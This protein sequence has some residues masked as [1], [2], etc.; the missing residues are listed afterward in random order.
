[1]RIF[2]SYAKEQ[3]DI[4]ESIALA[5]RSK[6]HTV[7]F[8]R[9]DL[10]AGLGYDDL[11]RKAINRSQL[12]IFII[13]PESIAAGRYT[14]TE[15][16]FARRRWPSPHGRVLPVRIRPTPME[17]IP[18]YLKAV[19]I[20]EPSGNTAT[21]VA[22]AVSAL[23]RGRNIRYRAASLGMGMAIIGMSFVL[24]KFYV[25][26]QNPP[27]EG[28]RPPV[29]GEKQEPSPVPD[30]NLDQSNWI[31]GGEGGMEITRNSTVAQSFTVGRTGI[32]ERIDVA[33]VAPWRCTPSQSLYISLVNMEGNSLGIKTYKTYE[34]HPAKV[35]GIYL[36]LT[37]IGI[38]VNKGEQYAI[39][40][41]SDA[42]PA[43]CTYAWGGGIETYSGGN[44][45]INSQP[46]LRDMK[47]RTYVR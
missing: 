22:E 25:H 41:K 6:R 11:I 10:P 17:N 20:L 47:F 26:P 1:M 16:A 29:S 43:N 31:S 21:E 8:D 45:F 2:I 15:L 12:L 4:A 14:L 44:A 36:S 39:I 7:F 34:F 24:W 18:P 33:D 37:G 40:L 32:L 3:R 9:D 23:N 38:R 42:E 35:S 28:V 13:S 19:T 27:D 5:L 30:P 46:N